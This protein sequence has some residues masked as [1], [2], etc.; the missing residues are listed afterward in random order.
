VTSVLITYS[1]GNTT[2]TA[3]ERV[4]TD[5]IVFNSGARD[6]AVVEDFEPLQTMTGG[7]VGQTLVGNLHAAV[8]LEHGQVVSD[9]AARTQAPHTLVRDSTTVGHTLHNNKLELMKR[10][11]FPLWSS[12][13]SGTFTTAFLS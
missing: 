3:Q 9:G 11:T 5:H 1:M 4:A 12:A 13:V 8:E 6:L 10:L 2:S 7:D